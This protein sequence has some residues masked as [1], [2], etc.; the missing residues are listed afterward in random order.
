MFNRMMI[1]T[2]YFRVSDSQRPGENEGA[3][4]KTDAA[5]GRQRTSPAALHHHENREFN[6]Q[7]GL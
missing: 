3:R 6:E 5:A 1:K 4:M 7:E 2:V